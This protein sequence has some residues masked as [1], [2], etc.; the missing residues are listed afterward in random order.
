MPATNTARSVPLPSAAQPES[1]RF[2]VALAVLVAVTLSL[3]SPV[4][5]NPF[6]DYDDPDYVTE[7][8]NVQAGLGWRLLKWSLTTTTAG[9]WHPLTWL[10]HGLDYQLFGLHP[11][12][13]HATS[14][15]L[16]AANGILLFLFLLESTRA[17]GCSFF[18]AALFAVHPINVES[19]AWVAE[20]KNVLCTFF[21]LLTLVSYC[22]YAR[23]RSVHKYLVTALLFIAG[24]ASKPMA[25]TLPC[26]LILADYW[27]LKRVRGFSESGAKPVESKRSVAMLI[28]EKLP[29]FFLSAV[30]A[31]VTIVAQRSAG[32]MVTIERLPLGLRLGNAFRSYILYLWKAVWP[33]DYAPFYPG[34]PLIAWH[35]VIACLM[36]LTATLFAY[37]QRLKRPYLLFGWLWFLGTLVPVIGLIQVGGQAMADR[38]AYIPLIGIFVAVVWGVA[39]FLDSRA[40][41]FGV[42]VSAAAFVILVF[43]VATWR[44]IGYWRSNYDLW[45]HASRVT[46]HNLIAEDSL[47]LT[48]LEADQYNE[49]LRHFQNARRIRPNDPTSHLNIGVILQQQGNIQGA[50]AEYEASILLNHDPMTL[51][52]AY[53]NLGTI[54]QANGNYSEARESF[55]RALKANPGQTDALFKLG[56]L[57][58]GAKASPANPN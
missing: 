36:L 57:E 13:H 29:F 15:L 50:I 4:L 12:G 1:R 56:Q 35:V 2:R 8:P 22:W 7:N 48:L 10:S 41:S 20:R 46:K 5:R 40:I 49:A 9:N 53:D 24:L 11:G 30:S 25:V 3:Y 34:D 52:I 38:Y 14:V 27:P 45:S 37:R 43:S 39:E 21:F 47:G 17:W 42:R 31:L 33:R 19:V 54:Y 32:A 58:S 23:K 28:V 6:I 44:Q 51:A 18:A 26:L 16:H 55:I